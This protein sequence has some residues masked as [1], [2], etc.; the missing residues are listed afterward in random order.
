MTLL[1][2]HC[3]KKCTISPV[4]VSYIKYFTK[5]LFSGV[6]NFFQIICIC[7]LN[8]FSPIGHHEIAVKQSS[9]NQSNNL[10]WKD[11]RNSC[12]RQNVKLEVGSITDHR[13]FV[14]KKWLAFC[15]SCDQDLK[16]HL[17]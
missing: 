11:P 13:Q 3:E 17:T 15:M 1:H 5:I 6:V 4:F 14:R 2:I 9:S 8:I 16:E 10:A 7:S 12:R